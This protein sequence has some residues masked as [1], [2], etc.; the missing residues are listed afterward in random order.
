MKTLWYFTVKSSRGLYAHNGGF[1]KG[2]LV[3]RQ[4]WYPLHPSEV[5]LKIKKKKK[6]KNKKS[7]DNL[8][9]DVSS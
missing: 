9:V 6:L 1:K 5:V 4:F 3:L 2:P 7:P 8:N